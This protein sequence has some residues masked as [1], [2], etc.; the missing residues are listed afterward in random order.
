MVFFKSMLWGFAGVVLAALLL[1]ILGSV[2]LM[3]MARQRAGE[4]S[5][6][7]WDPVSM[8]G[9]FGFFSYLAVAFI[10]AFL[11]AYRRLRV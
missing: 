3:W 6:I 4:I 5:G 7:G 10:M 1:L 11:L 9:W 2:M 8:L